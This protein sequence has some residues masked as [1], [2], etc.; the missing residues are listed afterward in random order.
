MKKIIAV[1]GPAGAGKSTV[2][3]IVAKKL[4]YTYIDTGA[5]YRAVGLKVLNRG[6]NFDE[7]FIVDTARDVDIKL[8]AAGKV[9]LDGDDVT[10]KIRTPE[11]G[12]AASDVAKIGF[13]RTKLTQLQREM[14]TQGSVVMDGRD[15]GTCV[16]PNADLKIFLT[17]SVDERARRRFEELKAKGHVTDFDTIRNEI[18]LRDKQDS[19]REIAPLK[20]ADDAILL[21]TTN[22]TIDEVVAKILELAS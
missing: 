7:N 22:L 6:G 13:V 10:Q 18:I 17:A 15:I 4:S 12:K 9:F 21:D 11:V 8:D 2:S 20:Q 3:K 19:Q 1:D 5:M 16:L 14:A